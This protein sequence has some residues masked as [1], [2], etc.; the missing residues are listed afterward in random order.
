MLILIKGPLGSGKTTLAGRLVEHLGLPPVEW[1]LSA[2]QLA[3]SQEFMGEWIDVA[4]YFDACRHVDLER[5]LTVLQMHKLAELPPPP[6][7]RPGAPVAEMMRWRGRIFDDLYSGR[8]LPD[9]ADLTCR[10]IAAL[11]HAV[12]EGEILGTSLRDSALTR[13]VRRRFARVPV[14][15]LRTAR[16]AAGGAVRYAV[17]AHGRQLDH[18]ELL[19][20]LWRRPDGTIGVD[21]SLGLTWTGAGETAAAG[22]HRTEPALAPA[23]GRQP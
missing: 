23:P 17:V 4:A 2:G 8:F 1:P 9:L 14:L 3:E 16:L 15:R 5:V 20:A 11:P 12:V 19:A 13:E 21:P 22:I 6:R 10:L 7:W 18:D